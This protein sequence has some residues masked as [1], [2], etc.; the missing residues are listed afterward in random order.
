MTNVGCYQASYSAG[1][2]PTELHRSRG[3]RTLC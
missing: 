3:S 1:I 2:A